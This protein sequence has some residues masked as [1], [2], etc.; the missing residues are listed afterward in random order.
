MYFRSSYCEQVL[1]SRRSANVFSA[2]SLK[3]HRSGK[4]NIASAV[5]PF[6][7]VPM[8]KKRE[9]Q[10]RAPQPEV[11]LFAVSYTSDAPKAVLCFNHGINEHVGRYDKGA[12]RRAQTPAACNAPAPCTCTIAVLASWCGRICAARCKL[13]HIAIAPLLYRQRHCRAC[14]HIMVECS[15]HL[16]D[17]ERRGLPL[18]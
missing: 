18:L 15:L 1:P 2:S 12:S 3:L 13:P 11:D 7:A 9:W 14:A 16:A 8:V 10:F 4:A 17:R 5:S 6:T